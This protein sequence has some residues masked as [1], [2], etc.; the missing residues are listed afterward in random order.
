MQCRHG[1]MKSCVAGGQVK[2]CCRRWC[3]VGLLWLERGPPKEGSDGS[4]GCSPI[5][6][7]AVAK[8]SPP[9][10]TECWRNRA[11]HGAVFTR[12]VGVGVAFDARTGA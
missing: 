1:T 10:E 12:P 7:L 5:C 8:M 3:V 11:V 9:K 4:K 2:R 6:P